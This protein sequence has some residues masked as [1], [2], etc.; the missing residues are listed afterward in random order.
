MLDKSRWPSEKCENGHNSMDQEDEIGL[1]EQETAEPA[2][3]FRKMPAERSE[4]GF[5]EQFRRA[6]KLANP[7]SRYAL[8][9]PAHGR[10]TMSSKHN[11]STAFS[12]I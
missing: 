6:P 5:I 1:P 4:S 11:L 10:S 12:F 2:S 9:L 7:K 8:R 3:R